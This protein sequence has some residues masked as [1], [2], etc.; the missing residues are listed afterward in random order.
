MMQGRKSWWADVRRQSPPIR[1]KVPHRLDRAAEEDV[2]V[3]RR[4][5]NHGSRHLS[6]SAHLKHVRDGHVANT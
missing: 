3:A 2:A 4:D 5:M 6:F 1:Q